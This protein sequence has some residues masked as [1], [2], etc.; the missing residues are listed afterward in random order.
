MFVIPN[1]DSND[2]R[3]A[4]EPLKSLRY[5]LIAKVGTVCLCL[6]AMAAFLL[7]SFCVILGSPATTANIL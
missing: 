5:L 2:V 6:I 3:K 7:D 4:Y 1:E